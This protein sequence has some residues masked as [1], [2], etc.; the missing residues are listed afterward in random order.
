MRSRARWRRSSAS[1]FCGNGVPS[2]VRR[3]SSFSAT[4]RMVGRNVRMPKRVNIAFIWLIIRVCSV[5]RFW[6]SRFGRLASSSSIVGIATMLQWRFSPRSQPRKTRIRSSVSRRS[7]FARRCS[8]DTAMLVGWM[9]SAPTSLARSQ[10]ASQNPVA[11]SLKGDDDTLDVAPSLAGFAAPTMQE[12]QQHFLV[13]IELLKR[14][15]LDAGNERCNQPLRLAQ[16]DHGDDCA[17]LLESGEGPARVKTKMLRHRGAPLVAVEQR[18]WCHALAARPIAS[19][20]K[21]TWPRTTGYEPPRNR[22]LGG[23]MPRPLVSRDCNRAGTGT[24]Y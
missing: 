8:R 10:R 16:L 23:G 12:L 9:T 21:R 7:V 11:A 15:A 3:S 5:I 20:Q 17:I 18:P 14:L 22:W 13:G 1:V 19:S 24:G 2:A 6:C 4:L